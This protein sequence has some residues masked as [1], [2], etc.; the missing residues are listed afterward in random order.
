MTFCRLYSFNAVPSIS[1]WDRIVASGFDLAG[2][3]TLGDTTQSA[4][5]VHPFSLRIALK[6]EG[7]NQAIRPVLNRIQKI[8]KPILR[9]K[10]VIFYETNIVS[11]G[12]T[13]D[14]VLL[15]IRVEEPVDGQEF[16]ERSSADDIRQF[17]PITRRHLRID[18]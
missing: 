15:L 2:F 1:L 12:S 3:R 16:S 11:V 8:F 14:K 6:N 4:I 5:E 9:Y 17:S 13:E 18:N 10:V 7:C